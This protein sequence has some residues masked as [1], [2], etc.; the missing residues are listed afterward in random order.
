MLAWFTQ[1]LLGPHRFVTARV[2]QRHPRFSP[3]PLTYDLSVLFENLLI[4]DSILVNK[5]I[6]AHG[7]LGFWGF[8]VLPMTWN[9]LP[10]K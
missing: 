1:V 2:L 8:G 10:K 7:V 5:T 6:F 3:L 9:G 4:T